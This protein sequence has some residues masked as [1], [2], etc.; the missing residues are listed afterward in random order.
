MESHA[1]GID[2]ESGE[3]KSGQELSLT[4]IAE[5]LGISR[6]PVREAFQTLAAE[7]LITL[8]KAPGSKPERGFF[9]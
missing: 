5:Q 2:P 3:Y 4:A 6:T 7:G 1:V 8:R 9:C